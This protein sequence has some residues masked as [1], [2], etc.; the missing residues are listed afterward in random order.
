MPAGRRLRPAA[1]DEAGQHKDVHQY[2]DFEFWQLHSML[3]EW[4]RELYG[5]GSITE[6][7]DGG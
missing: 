6:A 2:M 4:A 7:V 1:G 3:V 5:K